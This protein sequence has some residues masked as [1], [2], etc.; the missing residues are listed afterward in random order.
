MCAPKLE[1]LSK[2]VLQVQITFCLS[3]V[4]DGLIRYFLYLKIEKIFDI[5]KYIGTYHR[6]GQIL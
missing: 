1:K 2:K 5:S 6:L 4:Q 3:L